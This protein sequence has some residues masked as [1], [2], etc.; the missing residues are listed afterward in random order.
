M[1]RFENVSKIYH[2]G[3]FHKTVYQDL[4][5]EIPDGASLGICGANGAGKSTLMRLISGVEAPSS[6][7]IQRSGSCSWPIGYTSC[8]QSTLTGADNARFISRIYGRNERELLERVEE[9]AQLGPYLNQP[10]F[11]YSAGMS[12]R[13]SFGVSL[14]IDFDCYLVDEVTGAGDDR[15]RQKCEAALRHRAETGT[16]IM[17]SHDPGTLRSYC[18]TGA[19]LRNGEL[20][21]FDTIDEAIDQH[22]QNQ[23]QAA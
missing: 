13:L 23:L 5:F 17:I 18:S 11:T 6:G 16:L 20:T 2:V 9:F 12:A 22:H 19:V 1:I 7:R 10:I 15:F 8:F 3:K 4:N 21:F 14:A